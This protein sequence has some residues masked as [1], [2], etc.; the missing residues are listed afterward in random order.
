MSDDL[1]KQVAQ[2]CRAIVHMA[3][4]LADVYRDKAGMGRAVYIRSVSH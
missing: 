4:A 3:T 1:R 2:Q